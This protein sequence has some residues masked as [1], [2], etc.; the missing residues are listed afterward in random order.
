MICPH[1]LTGIHE[2][3]NEWSRGDSKDSEYYWAA[4][5]MRCSECGKNIIKLCKR[6][7][8]APTIYGEIVYPRSSGR[9]PVPAE[10][11]EKFAIDYKEACAVLKDSPKASS[12]LS[13]RCLQLIL[14]EKAEL[15]VLNVKTG[16]VEDKKIVPGVLDSEI[17]QVLDNG[18]L[19]SAIADNLD[20]V[21][22]IGNFAA[23]P[24]KSQRSGEIVEVEPDEAEWNLDVVES[25]FDYYFVQPELA[26][27]K[28]AAMNQKL[29]EAGK[30]PLKTSA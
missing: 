27:Q 15:K 4:Y 18:G 11:D 16:K 26:Q 17:Q 12:A 28:R 2:D 10:V 5:L 23:H 19:P 14:E 6:F 21:R 7:H 20:A 29:Q 3:F 22:V 8:N 25:L 13:R 24:I 9:P 30:K 1:C